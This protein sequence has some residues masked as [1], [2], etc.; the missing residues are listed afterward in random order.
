[1]KRYASDCLPV[2]FYTDLH[3]SWKFKICQNVKTIV[4]HRIRVGGRD[5]IR[6]YI[7]LNTSIYLFRNMFCLLNVYNFLNN[8]TDYLIIQNIWVKCTN[9]V[10]KLILRIYCNYSFMKKRFWF[11]KL[12]HNL[13]SIILLLLVRFS[14]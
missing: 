10:F 2:I 5:R 6:K 9:I 8:I 14:I 4:I 1:M 7:S 11:S 3:N 13:K 12:N